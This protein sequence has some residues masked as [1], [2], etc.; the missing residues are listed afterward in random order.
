MYKEHDKNKA[1][2][3]NGSRLLGS[4][5]SKNPTT[6]DEVQLRQ[7][8]EEKLSGGEGKIITMTYMMK[9]VHELEVYQLEMEMQNEELVLAKEKAELTEKKYT[10]LYDFAPSGYLSLSKNGEIT[11]LNLMA[12]KMLGK[13]RSFLINKTFLSF[14]KKET[15][16]V[17]NQFLKNIFIGKAK[18]SCEIQ[19]ETEG[20]LAVYVNV[21]GIVAQNDGKC[22][23][24]LTDI[25]QCKEAAIELTKA[26]ERAEESDRLKSA[27][28]ANMSH[29]IR[30]PMNGIL[31]FAELL[32]EHDLSNEK[33]QYYISI[34]EKSGKHML[35]IINNIIDMSKIE[36][37]LVMV[38]ISKS[39]I[40]KQT[41]YVYTF[42]KPEVEKKGMK[43]F[44]KNGLPDGLSTV[45]TDCE[46]IYAILFNLVKNA[47]KFSKAG[48]IELGYNKKGN[49]LEFYVKDTGIGIPKDK[50]K[51]IF[52]RFIQA[53]S[54]NMRAFD[55]TGLGLCISKSYV[56]MLGGS[57]W[58]ESDEDA[59]STFYFN[60]PYN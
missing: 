1:R 45:E 26:K 51:S 39:D 22:L 44:I 53:D 49:W 47:I 35:N 8:A 58:V 31:G 46:K 57:I 32:A 41:E 17:F 29:E 27:F 10:E 55:G 14:V 19:L 50:Q 5:K 36:S 43:F 33:Q 3:D 16:P 34:I 25:T 40:N 24:T 38:N 11:Q 48:Y 15:Q 30:T 2:P 23:L 12:A 13:E 18:Q 21:E 42:F 59:G 54:S 6:S 56:E 9:L 4:K 60:I 37:G 52:E 7:K 28:L 20:E